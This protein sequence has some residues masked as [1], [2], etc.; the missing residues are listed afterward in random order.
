MASGDVSIWV[1][2]TFIDRVGAALV[3]PRRA[4]AVADT[5]AG[6][7]RAGSDAALLILLG[8]IA[9]YTN[10]VIV[11]TW[12]IKTEGLR[13]GFTA[14]AGSLS[15][16]ISN[17]LVVL[18]VAGL[19]LTIAAGRRRSFGRDFDLACVALVP[20]LVTNFAA[21]MLS[22]AFGFALANTLADGVTGV[23]LAWAAFVW[24]RA[25]QQARR[26]PGGDA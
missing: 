20:Y 4:L 1:P 14:L 3:A 17:Q 21:Q 18:F 6:A 9:L 23:A 10:E 25:L 13:V 16:A 7:G 12:L 5:E 8:F 22:R 26:R 19:S 24:F 2:G 11:G 15:R